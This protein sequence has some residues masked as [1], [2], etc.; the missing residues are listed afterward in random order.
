MKTFMSSYQVTVKRF[1]TEKVSQFRLSVL[2][3][4]SP[5]KK[6]F[7]KKYAAVASFFLF[8]FTADSCNPKTTSYISDMGF[9]KRLI[10]FCRKKSHF[11]E[12]HIFLYTKNWSSAFVKRSL[13]EYFILEESQNLGF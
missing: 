13:I 10:L 12:S 11:C 8:L 5:P 1:S 3:P 2:P 7:S 6:P 4:L 9:Q